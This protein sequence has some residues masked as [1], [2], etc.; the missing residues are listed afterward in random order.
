MIGTKQRQC[1]DT[2][3]VIPAAVGQINFVLIGASATSCI[4][5]NTSFTLR[6]LKRI[7]VKVAI[8]KYAC[9]CFDVELMKEVFP[10]KVNSDLRHLL[11]M[12]PTSTSA[13]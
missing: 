10:T 11:S 1:A 12:Q 3:A 2:A 4:E 7:D 13:I 6:E 8:A 5:Y 9:G